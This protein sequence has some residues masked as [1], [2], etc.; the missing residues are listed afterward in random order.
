MIKKKHLII[1]MILLLILPGTVWG[2]DDA[3]SRE[4][5]KGIKGVLV[6]IEDVDPRIAKDGLTKN[7]IEADVELKLRLAGL[8]VYKVM[9]EKE[10]PGL[11]WLYVAGEGFK[12]SPTGLYVFNIRVEL[13]QDVYLQRNGER[14]DATTWSI[15]YFGVSPSIDK[16]RNLIKDKVDSFINAW[17]SVNPKT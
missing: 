5:L 9:T 12:D 17:L 16:I 4:S 10:S 1:F 15:G 14:N 8:K 3:K 11:P 2:I 6:I 13:W 7:Q